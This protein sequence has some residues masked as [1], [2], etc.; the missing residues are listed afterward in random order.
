MVSRPAPGHYQRAVANI[1]PNE[2]ASCGRLRAVH[3]VDCQVYRYYESVSSGRLR[4]S[5]PSSRGPVLSPRTETR[6]SRR[7]V[8]HL[9]SL[10][11]GVHIFHL[12]PTFSVEPGFVLLLLERLHYRRSG[13]MQAP[14]QPG[15]AHGCFPRAVVPVT[16]YDS[17]R[18][19]YEDL[20]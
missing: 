1:V 15:W 8:W 7:F 19:A 3:Q 18:G 13:I 14:A 5:V 6:R 2:Q 11:L 9:R 4:G 16:S 10:H 20:R 12:F 17:R